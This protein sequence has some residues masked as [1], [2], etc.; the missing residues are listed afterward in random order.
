[1]G[2]VE[3]FL[4]KVES[5]KL[6][7]LC[8]TLFH[9]NYWINPFKWESSQLAEV[10]KGSK[11]LKSHRHL[12]KN[13]QLQGNLF[14]LMFFFYSFKLFKLLTGQSNASMKVGGLLSNVQIIW[15]TFSRACFHVVGVWLP[16][17]SLPIG[18]SGWHSNIESDQSFYWCRLAQT[19]RRPYHNKCRLSVLHFVW[20]GKKR[21]SMCDVSLTRSISHIQSMNQTLNSINCIVKSI[22][23]KEV[24]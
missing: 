3:T 8:I 14:I 21:F 4:K 19:C 5:L 15:L 22:F 2:W 6:E 17:S 9:A 13:K 12:K 7:S 18:E 1:M 16:P 11:K 10:P 20:A 23:F 24:N